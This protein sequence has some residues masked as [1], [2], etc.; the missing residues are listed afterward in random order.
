MTSKLL[1][2]KTEESRSNL[3]LNFIF[4]YIIVIVFKCNRVYARSYTLVIIT[5]EINYI[6][7]TTIKYKM[8]AP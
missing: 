6:G 7:I 1:N 3:I 8:I 5:K 2:A 4:I